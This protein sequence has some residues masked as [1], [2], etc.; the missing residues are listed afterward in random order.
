MATQKRPCSNA[1][2]DNQKEFQICEPIKNLILNTTKMSEQFKVYKESQ[3]N[4]IYADNVYVDNFDLGAGNTIVLNEATAGNKSVN[5]VDL[6]FINQTAP[7]KQVGGK[8]VFYGS[9]NQTPAPG[10]WNNSTTT[11]G[12]LIFEFPLL[13]VRGGLTLYVKNIIFTLTDAEAGVDY[14]S[15]VALVTDATAIT[16]DSTQYGTIA[17]H[18]V[19][20]TATAVA[21]TVRHIQVAFSVT[22]ANA[23][24]I[25]LTKCSLE[26]YYA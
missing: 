20:R 15:T 26:Y 8:V 23:N 9:W 6:A 12:F 18:T 2:I 16:T 3:F 25:K 5:M 11:P 19:S 13:A 21:S 10:S 17:T 1:F 14:I 7:L 22:S 24:A 4:D